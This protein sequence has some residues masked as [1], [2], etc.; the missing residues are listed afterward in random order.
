MYKTAHGHSKNRPWSRSDCLRSKHYRTAA[1]SALTNSVCQNA[2]PLCI[3]LPVVSTG[4]RHRSALTTSFLLL[5]MVRR[6]DPWTE[7]GRITK[8]KRFE[9]K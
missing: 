6:S 1:R 7:C 5:K 2:Q 3:H 9:H 8:N 4:R